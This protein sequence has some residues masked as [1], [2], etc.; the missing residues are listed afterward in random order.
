[1][2]LFQKMVLVPSEQV[3]RPRLPPG[4]AITKQAQLDESL[5]DTLAA[6]N[7]SEYDKRL[8]WQQDFDK[9]LHFLKSGKKRSR[10]STA[11]H[12]STLQPTAL[13]PVA[14]NQN[15][16]QLAIAPAVAEV[17]EE[18]ME[19]VIQTLAHNPELL[20]FDRNRQIIHK[21]VVVPDT[22][23]IDAYSAFVSQVPPRVKP[24]G[25]ALL[26]DAVN[27]F[28]HVSEPASPEAGSSQLS[29]EYRPRPTVTAPKE[30]K[31]L[32]N[33]PPPLALPPSHT[34]PRALERAPPMAALEYPPQRRTRMLELESV[35]PLP[36]LEQPVRV[37]ALQSAP[38]LLAIEDAAESMET[39]L[40]ST[41][42]PEPEH[43]EAI[44]APANVQVPAQVTP[45]LPR[46]LL[47]RL[48]QQPI[49][50]GPSTVDGTRK[51]KVDSS[52]AYS[53]EEPE[54]DD[55]VLQAAFRKRRPYKLGAPPRLLAIEAPTKGGGRRRSARPYRARVLALP[56]PPRRQLA[57]PAPSQRQLALPAPPLRQLALPAPSRQLELPGPPRQLALPAPP[58]DQ[59]A[60]PAPP[61]SRGVKRKADTDEA[62]LDRRGSS[63]RYRKLAANRWLTV[64]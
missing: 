34:L 28:Y 51:R 15:N 11:H 16:Q 52:A 31:R 2:S 56:A 59:L 27:Q 25:Y 12:R 37:R 26:Q 22:D 1:M 3:T 58:Q 50:A 7:L 63:P 39:I 33:R 45:P 55:E 17:D 49:P 60:L 8:I 29:L 54:D 4:A 61:T 64:H 47:R 14:T 24:P 36:M 53:V 32:A 38:A 23:F 35:A 43:M 62:V 57:L 46:R 9:Y 10:S 40:D 13:A 18:M 19:A 48:L 41:D 20:S 42:Q 44:I 5:S 21:G 6:S 30:R